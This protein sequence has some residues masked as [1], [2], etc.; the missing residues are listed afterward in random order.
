MYFSDT[1]V[2]VIKFNNQVD[3]LTGNAFLNK[4]GYTMMAFSPRAKAF[5]NSDF[6]GCTGL[7][8]ITFGFDNPLASSTSLRFTSIGANCFKNC[9]SLTHFNFYGY[10]SLWTEVTLGSSWSSGLGAEIVK[11]LD[12]DYPL[13]GADRITYTAT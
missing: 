1:N 10:I 11:C 13:T 4:T 2:G 7:T 5:D 3:R 12:G 9:S 6:Q 8:H